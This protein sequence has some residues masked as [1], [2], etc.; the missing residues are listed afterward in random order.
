MKGKYKLGV[1]VGSS[2]YVLY[3]GRY[4]RFS[5][6]LGKQNISLTESYASLAVF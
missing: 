3:S 1:I 4:L 5:E 6:V 2:I